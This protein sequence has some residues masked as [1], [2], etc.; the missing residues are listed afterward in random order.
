MNNA[1]A[2]SVYNV[3][4]CA[5]LIGFS[6]ISTLKCISEMG[7]SF[8]ISFTSLSVFCLIRSFNCTTICD[9]F[10]SFVIFQNTHADIAFCLHD[11]MLILFLRKLL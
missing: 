5:V 8:N 9:G 10:L 1:I 7:S 4:L 11:A 2:I 6:I 3:G